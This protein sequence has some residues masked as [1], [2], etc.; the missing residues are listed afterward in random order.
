MNENTV[1]DA[2]PILTIQ[3]ILDNLTGAAVFSSLNLN[4]GYWQVEMDPEV[5]EITA[6]ICPP[7]LFQ[8]KVVPFGLKNAPA[9]FQRLMKR[10]LQGTERCNLFRVLEQHHHFLLVLG[11]TFL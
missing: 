1:T 10:A 6:F 8:F 4:S 2:Y 11:A 3:E 5:R 7:G 9:M